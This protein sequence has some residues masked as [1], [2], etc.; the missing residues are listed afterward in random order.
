MILL[1]NLFFISRFPSD[2][3]LFCKMSE[4]PLKCPVCKPEFE[5][6]SSQDFFRHKLTEHHRRN[7]KKATNKKKRMIKDRKIMKK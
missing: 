5:A 2:L 7:R 3:L 4:N 1:I 6:K